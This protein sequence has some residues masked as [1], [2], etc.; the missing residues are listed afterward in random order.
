MFAAL[1]TAAL[2]NRAAME[3]YA[4]TRRAQDE[5]AA[6]RDRLHI[7]S[8]GPHGAK[9]DDADVDEALWHMD[10]PSIVTARCNRVLAQTLHRFEAVEAA[11]TAEG[12]RLRARVSP[13][14]QAAWAP[15]PAPE[16]ALA[17]KVDTDAAA[18]PARADSPAGR[19]DE[20]EPL[21]P[22]PRAAAQRQT[23]V[24]AP[25][26]EVMDNLDES[27]FVRVVPRKQRRAEEAVSS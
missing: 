9:A 4:T 18:A 15:S 24:F 1:R 16:A 20:A 11:L 5:R 2:L 26:P 25:E 7:T 14:P 12:A 3:Q 13:R 19:A 23:D 10:D 27:E 8:H 21:L 22:A 17:V 6:G